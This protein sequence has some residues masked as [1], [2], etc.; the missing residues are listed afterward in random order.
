MCS[1]PL[2]LRLPSALNPLWFRA[3]GRRTLG[4]DFVGTHDFQSC[5]FNR[6]G[7]SPRQLNRSQGTQHYRSSI[8]R[9]A[10]YALCELRWLKDS[11]L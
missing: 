3:S 6:S 1:V 4:P 9:E 11:F 2:D 5:P 7:I 10:N 8:E